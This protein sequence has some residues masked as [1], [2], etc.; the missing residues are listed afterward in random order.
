MVQSRGKEPSETGFVQKVMLQKLPSIL[1]TALV[2]MSNSEDVGPT[3][4]P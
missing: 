2:K 3:S 4:A 1:P